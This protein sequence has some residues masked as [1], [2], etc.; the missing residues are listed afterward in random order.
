M[1]GWLPDVP[2]L[3]MAP[4]RGWFPDIVPPAPPPESEIG[5]WAV[6]TLDIKD[7]GDTTQSMVLLA[8]K[9]LALANLAAS[10]Q[11]LELRRIATAILT[12]TATSSQVL[13]LRKIAL[14]NLAGVAPATQ[15]LS[16]AKVLDVELSRMGVS[17]QSLD[18]ARVVNVAMMTDSPAAQ[19][20]TLTKVGVLALNSTAPSSQILV[21]TRVVSLMLSTTLATASGVLGLGF[22]PLTATTQTFTNT[23]NI[24]SWVF[25]RNAEWLA[26]VCLGGGCGGRGG[27]PLL[28]GGGGYAGT[29]GTAL[30]KR[31][32]DVPWSMTSMYMNVGAGSAGSSGGYV[33]SNPSNGANSLCTD[34][35]LNAFAVGNGGLPNYST[36][37]GQDAAD[38][39]FNGIAA[40]GGKSTTG[41]ASPGGVPGGG[42]NGA[43]AG[44]FGLPG[45]A[46]GPG[47]RGQIWARAFQ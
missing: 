5:W 42:G 1:A 2:I 40:V 22:P 41:S 9:R 32:V 6:L 16:L 38:L 12:N 17:T 37:R 47:G 14:L 44:S 15:A 11:S 19:L 23:N 31:G 28:A 24:A 35:S 43:N 25:P 34:T 3:R 18:L 27:G 21:L 33:V 13:T 20:L 36:Q 26:V 10:T 46:G 8:I 4:P 39:N 29:Y 30:L 7:L 45:G